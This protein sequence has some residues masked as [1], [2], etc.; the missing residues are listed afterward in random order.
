MSRRVIA[1]TNLKYEKYTGHSFR[2][3]ST[4]I[5]ANQGVGIETLKRHGPWKS[6]TVCEGYIQNSLAQKRKV[7]SLI[8]NAICLSSTSTVG[9]TAEVQ[10]KKRAPLMS[11]SN[12]C[13]QSTSASTITETDRISNQRKAT[14][15]AVE[16]S[17]QISVSERVDVSSD[18]FG[19]PSGDSTSLSQ[20]IIKI[21]FPWNKENIVFHFAGQ[22]TNFNV[23]MKQ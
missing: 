13:R 20:T 1:L 19:G 5:L 4:T 18:V 2:R 21:Q 10:P 23:N 15:I 3:T 22:I 16:S 9:S 17:S 7:G 14:S 8:S 11:V 6:N 12:E